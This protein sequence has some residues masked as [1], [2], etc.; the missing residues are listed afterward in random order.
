MTV[1]GSLYLIGIF[2]IFLQITVAISICALSYQ[3]LS[4]LFFGGFK[5]ISSENDALLHSCF[6]T[7]I[8][9]AIF[10]PVTSIISNSILSFDIDDKLQ[11][12]QIFYSTL[13][14]LEFAF[15]MTVVVAHKIRKCAFSTV[16]R[17]TILISIFICANQLIQ[18]YI[19]A[20]L[21]FDFYMP[22]YKICTVLFNVATLA[23]I[24]IYPIIALA[25]IKKLKLGR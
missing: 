24:G 11:L 1:N 5:D 10:H 9:V 20:I 2:V 4:K 6:L 15:L 19:R 23:T 22:V 21:G 8:S 3:K 13:F 14:F 17:I 16:A 18:F 25:R 12:R 7:A